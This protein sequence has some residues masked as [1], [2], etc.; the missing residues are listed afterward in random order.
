MVQID[1]LLL[2]ILPLVPE[3]SEQVPHT[4]SEIFLGVF[5]DLLHM[6]AQLD[7]ALREYQPALK[8]EG[9]QLVGELKPAVMET[10]NDKT[11]K[12]CLLYTSRCV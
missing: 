5:Q 4:R 7:W 12:D 3:Q 11:N 8:Q 6:L 10:A 1:H 9:T 2:N